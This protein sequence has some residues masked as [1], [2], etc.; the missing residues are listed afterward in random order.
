M[1]ARAAAWRR[2]RRA[3]PLWSVTVG[4]FLVLL[5]LPI[6]SIAA[7]SLSPADNVWPKLWAS[8]LPGAVRDTLL[9]ASLTGVVTLA[10][11][12]VSAWLVTMYR[13]PGRALLD[14]LLVIPLAMPAYI[15]AYTY[16]DLLAY[17]GPIQSGLRTVFAL[18]PGAP[19]L[20]PD[21]RSLGG[22]VFVMSAALYPYVYLGARASFV[23]QSVCAL[24]VAR[25]L[26]QTPMGVFW[27]VAL[28]M[29]R[30]A[31]VASVALV[32]MECLA[33]LAAVQHLGVTTLTSSIYATWLQ[34]SNIGGAA[35]IAMVLLGLVAV[36]YLIEHWGQGQGRTHGATGRYR[37]IP[38][39]ELPG[40]KGW[41]ACVVCGIPF[42]I[43]F[44]IPA[45]VLMRH[46]S[47]HFKDALASGFMLAAWHSLALSAVAAAAAIAVALVFTYAQ[48]VAPN[49]LTRP[50]V[51]VAGL[52]YALPGTVLAIGLLIPL[53]A[54]DN[55]LDA[56]MRSWVG[57]STGLILTGS[58]AALTLAYV[59]RFLAVAIGALDAGLSRISPNLDAAARALG[60]TALSALFRVH[61]PMLTP[62]LAAGA[63]L[64]FVDAMKELP[65]TLLMRPFNFETLAT[66]I[67]AMVA[68]E[69]FEEAAPAAL[70]IVV[71]GL[72][73]VLLL[74]RTL[75]EGRAGSG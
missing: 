34:R 72:I 63:L 68:V 14:R 36:V 33:D 56:A 65:A 51:K 61:L 73:P 11:G 25:T 17:A 54:L 57:L 44:L 35:Q 38:F 10:V 69:R 45:L 18:P 6:L 55:A 3:S 4:A 26:G 16:S 43:G 27:S 23:Q 1:R 60:E 19:A 53:G 74:H 15:L 47:V 24:E 39:H 50:A 62:A 70:M 28:P 67:Y 64:V 31:L 66:H 59:T 40:A 52:G 48:R 29:A 58:I 41:L 2:Q 37:S 75:A 30:P 5:L 42:V 46:A 21:I 49:G 13:F 8:V 7:M 9:L 12:T 71:A 22:A 32:M 20:L